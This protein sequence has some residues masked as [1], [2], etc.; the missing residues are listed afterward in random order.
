MRGMAKVLAAA[1]LAGSILGALCFAVLLPPATLIVVPVVLVGVVAL[2]GQ[3]NKAGVGTGLLLLGLTAMTVAGNISTKNDVGSLGFSEGMGIAVG[4]ASTQALAASAI[5]LRWDDLGPRWLTLGSL[6]SCLAAAFLA[7]SQSQSLTNHFRIGTVLGAV[8]SL[9]PAAAL[10]MA[11][12]APPHAAP[13]AKTAT[14][15]P[16]QAKTG[17]AKAPVRPASARPPRP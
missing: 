10:V 5:A 7:L 3:R 9:A 17:T 2:F 4:I 15:A 6:L 12:R 13:V 16:T 14:S 1:G 11:L 8:L